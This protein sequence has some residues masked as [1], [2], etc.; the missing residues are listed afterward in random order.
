[1]E[2]PAVVRAIG[3]LNALLGV[4]GLVATAVAGAGCAAAG[5]NGYWQVLGMSDAAR[6][7]AVASGIVLL[8]IGDSI[9]QLASGIGLLR[10]HGWGLSAA[11][12]YAWYSL[13]FAAVCGFLHF[14][15]FYSACVNWL[16]LGPG[17]L[18]RPMAVTLA[19]A[20][21]TIG[22][23]LLG[24]YPFVTLLCLRSNELR[25]T[26]EAAQSVSREDDRLALIPQ[27]TL[28]RLLVLM[29][30]SSIFF[31]VLGNAFAGRT[32]AIAMSLGTVSLVAAFAIYGA[33]FFL[34]WVLSLIWKPRS[35]L[36][37]RPSLA[38]PPTVPQSPFQPV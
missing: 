23:L 3:S 5:W 29:G 37:A 11:R 33:T 13:L 8:G 19:I 28:R 2:L 35:A 14:T 38:P 27:F 22:P 20:A 24:I 25:A 26:L 32:W 12:G 4:A 1:M 6:F 9:I 10:M 30:V 17:T 34:V 31:L 7:W 21:G 15:L 36:A 16:T 18:S